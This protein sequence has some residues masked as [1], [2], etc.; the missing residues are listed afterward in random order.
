M[1]SIIMIFLNEEQFIRE[2]IESVFAQS[3][4]TWELLLVDDG[5]MDL[6]TD[7]ALRCADQHPGQVR[8]L[9][10]ADHQNRGMSASRNLGISHAKGKHIAFLDADDVWSPHKLEQQVVSSFR[11]I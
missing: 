10:H 8:Y 5:S 2:A 6:S 1:V 4:D 3:Y 9:E 7:I 11:Q